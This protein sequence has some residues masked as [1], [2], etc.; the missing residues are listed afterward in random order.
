MGIRCRSLTKGRARVS[1]LGERCQWLMLNVVIVLAVVTPPH[2]L[3]GVRMDVR[4]VE[5]LSK[6]FIFQGP[7]FKVTSTYIFMDFLHGII[8]FC[9]SKAA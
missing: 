9:W 5:S 3:N 4:S 6:D 1:Q 8:D 7:S 2:R